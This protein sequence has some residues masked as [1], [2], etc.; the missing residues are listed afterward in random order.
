MSSPIVIGIGSSPPAMHAFADLV[1]NVLQ[2]HDHKSS[3]WTACWT[4][5]GHGLDTSWACPGHRIN[6]ELSFQD[7]ETIREV[8]GSTVHMLCV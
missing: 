4:C 3:K 5:P 8:R 1:G 6:S 7:M 2:E